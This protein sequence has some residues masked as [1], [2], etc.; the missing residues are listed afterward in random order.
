MEYVRDKL[1]WERRKDFEHKFIECTWV[2][3][4]CQ[5]HKIFSY[6]QT[7]VGACIF[8]KKMVI[9]GTLFFSKDVQNPNFGLPVQP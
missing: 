9:Q 7:I 8:S 4:F 2:E 6:H 3:I 1:I 5:T